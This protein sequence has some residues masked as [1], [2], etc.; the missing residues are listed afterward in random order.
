[1]HRYCAAFP[2]APGVFIWWQTPSSPAQAGRGNSIQMQTEAR[3]RPGLQPAGSP[4][5]R[6]WKGCRILASGKAIQAAA[7]GKSPPHPATF[8]PSGLARRKRARPEG[9]KVEIILCP[10][11]RAALRLPGAIITSSLRDF[12]L[13][14]GA[15]I[16]QRQGERWRRTPSVRICKQAPP[17]AIRS[18]EKLN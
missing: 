8:F 9:K 1:M 13:A 11:P 14:R 18:T 4:L 2:I 12:R 16:V 15:R 6:P 7:L 3:P 5:R 10:Q 17:A